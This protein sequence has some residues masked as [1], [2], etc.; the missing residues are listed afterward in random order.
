MKE[1]LKGK[2]KHTKT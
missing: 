2:D 1:K